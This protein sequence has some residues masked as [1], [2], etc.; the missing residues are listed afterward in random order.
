MNS[1]HITYFVFFPTR[2]RAEVEDARQKAKDDDDVGLQFWTF[3]L[4]TFWYFGEVLLIKLWIQY[5][6][7]VFKIR[8]HAYGHE[9][10]AP[11]S[12][13]D[14]KLFSY[15]WYLIFPCGMCSDLCLHVQVQRT[16]GTFW[17]FFVFVLLEILTQKYKSLI[18][19]IV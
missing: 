15:M 2:A 6:K 13:P 17:N 9:Q 11:T 14:A 8:R 1:T 12:Y 16:T 19:K 10:D 18:I 3:Y 5:Y 4:T 7:D